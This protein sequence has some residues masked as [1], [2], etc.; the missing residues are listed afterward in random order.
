MTEKRAAKIGKLV[1]W[2][3]WRDDDYIYIDYFGP[4][5]DVTTHI[6]DL[7]FGHSI[8]WRR[9]ELGLIIGYKFIDYFDVGK[10][11]LCDILLPSGIGTC[12]VDEI[13]V[14]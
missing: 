14:I 10:Q 9:G 12:H 11:K 2:R 7:V 5:V 13:K 3:A 1:D 6:H 4:E 8:M